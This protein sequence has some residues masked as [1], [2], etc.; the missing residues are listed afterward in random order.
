MIIDYD[1]TETRG[2]ADFRALRESMGLTPA[3][4][5]YLMEVDMDRV[6]KWEK[7]K[8]FIPPRAAWE[9]LDETRAWFDA[10]VE[11]LVQKVEAEFPSPSEAT[12]P[13]IL[14]YWRTTSYLNKNSREGGSAGFRNAISR[15]ASYF[16][17][18]DGYKTRFEYV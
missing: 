5:G 16:L 3:D 4:L 2:K 1:E 14:P 11:K 18:A 12:E 15:E 17:Q 13:V 7:P 6:K 8:G 9:Q 10:E